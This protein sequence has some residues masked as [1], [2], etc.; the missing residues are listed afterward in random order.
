MAGTDIKRTTNEILVDIVETIDLV[1]TSMGR[2]DFCHIRGEINVNTKLSG[3]P[4]CKLVLAGN[5]H[6]EDVQFHRSVEV[7]TTD[8]KILPF[9]P[10]DGQFTLMKYRL[11]AVQQTV[12]L[13]IT[14]TFQWNKGS[15]SFDISLKPDALLTKELQQ[16]EITFSFPLG[17]GI[18]ALVVVDGRAAY[19]QSNRTVTWTIPIYGKKEVT[20]L[21]GSASTES[22]F[23]LAGRFPVV[24]AKFIYVG[25]TTSGFKIQGLEVENVDYQPFKGVKYIST[26]GSYEFMSGL[27]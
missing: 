15:V 14:P 4:K 20:V 3:N 9:I 18:P 8:A 6:F 11:T 12:P 19:D 10:P 21:K 2:V 5:T 13:W 24:S 27:I 23:D 25:Q 26:G 7:D 17:V 16:I 22:N 1:V